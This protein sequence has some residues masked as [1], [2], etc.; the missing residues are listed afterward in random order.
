MLVLAR[1]LSAGCID[2]T[3]D[4]AGAVAASAGRRSQQQPEGARQHNFKLPGLAHT[5]VL[6]TM[7]M[8]FLVIAVLRR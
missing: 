3:C 6:E 2:T 4:A 7:C 1:C 5:V 8:L